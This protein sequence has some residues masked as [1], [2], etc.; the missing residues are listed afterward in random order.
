M[1]STSIFALVILSLTLLYVT[2][3]AFASTQYGVVEV[4]SSGGLLGIISGLFSPHKTVSS[5]TA[6]SVTSSQAGIV[7]TNNTQDNARLVLFNGNLNCNAIAVRLSGIDATSNGKVC[8]IVIVRQSPQNLLNNFIEFQ[9]IDSSIINHQVFVVGDF[10]LLQTEMNSVQSIT[11]N[12]GW[13]VSGIHN[14]LVNNQT[15]TLMHV[16]V[17]NDIDKVISQVNQALID[18][19]IKSQV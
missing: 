16:E 12:N 11:K 7:R 14:P 18:T 6:N 19:K 17:Q 9:K 3:Y 8:D 5:D 1:K 4:K 2:H 10:A 15:M 13:V